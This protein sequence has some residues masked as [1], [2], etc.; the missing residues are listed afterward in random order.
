MIVIKSNRQ[1]SRILKAKLEKSIGSTV[2]VRYNCI[3]V[4]FNSNRTDNIIEVLKEYK[5]QNFKIVTFTDKQ[6]KL[7]ANKWGYKK[8]YLKEVQSLPLKHR[9]TWFIDNKEGIQSVTPITTKQLNNI[10]KIN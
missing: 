8:D 9:F 3:E 5:K 10:I 1:I 6:F 7:T 2:F 4:F